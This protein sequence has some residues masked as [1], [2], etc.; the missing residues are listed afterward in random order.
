MD[1][2]N[3]LRTERPR[4]DWPR[5]DAHPWQGTRPDGT[6]IGPY[7]EQESIDDYMKHHNR[8]KEA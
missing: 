1:K 5:S 7:N 6:P 4:T 8:E 2:K 3:P